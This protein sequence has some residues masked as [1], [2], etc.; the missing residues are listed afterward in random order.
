MRDNQV[1]AAVDVAR[2]S[3]R[4]GRVLEDDESFVERVEQ[5]RGAVLFRR[6]EGGAVSLREDAAGGMRPAMGW[7]VMS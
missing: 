1:D 6:A 2:T 5:G 4:V 7:E 3:G